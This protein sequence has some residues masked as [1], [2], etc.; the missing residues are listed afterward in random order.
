MTS[1]SLTI[2]AL[3]IFI[4]PLFSAFAKADQALNINDTAPAFFI[5]EFIIKDSESIK[6]YSAKVL[7]TLAAFGGEFMVRR[8]KTASLEGSDINGDIV[9][10]KFP[11]M[12]KALGW[13]NS[14]EY[15]EIRPIRHKAASTR[16]YIVEG[17]L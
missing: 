4:A 9:I 12:E 7:S 15:S 11:S 10:I 8:G 16:A 6:P 13:Y 1:K 3:S 17:L 5:A 2:F 14:P